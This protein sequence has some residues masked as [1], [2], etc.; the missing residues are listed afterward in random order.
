MT[1]AQFGR[2]LTLAGPM[3]LDFTGIRCRVRLIGRAI[4]AKRNNRP[5]D[6]HVPM[7]PDGNRIELDFGNPGIG[8]PSDFES[9]FYL[10]EG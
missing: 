7:V 1:D 9:W 10:V 4:F 5:L 6:G 8:Q 3:E 2:L